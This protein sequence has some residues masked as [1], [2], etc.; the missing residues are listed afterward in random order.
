V[1]S[2]ERYLLRDAS[3]QRMADEMCRG[4]TGGIHD[5]ERVG[6]HQLNGKRRA[7]RL[8]GGHTTIVEG[9]C[10]EGAAEVGDLRQPAIAMKANTLDKYDR[11]PGALVPKSE[12]APLK[13]RAR[14]HVS[15]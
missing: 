5:G 11:L 2:S 7:E 4:D 9:D 15:L 6:S 8:R 1:L 13:E 12:R 14:R 10:A 3:T